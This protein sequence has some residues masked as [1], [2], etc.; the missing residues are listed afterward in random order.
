MTENTL[1]FPTAKDDHKFVEGE[2]DSFA[3]EEPKLP[4]AWAEEYFILMPGAG[5]ASTGKLVLYPWQIEPLNAIAKYNSVIYC[6]PVQ[7]G[8]SLIAEVAV[9]YCV[10]TYGFHGMFCYA[11]RDTVDKEP[12]CFPTSCVSLNQS[13]K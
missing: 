1:I 4:S 6:G 12:C 9:W 5:Y 13:K 3:M 2:R 10:D 7:T 8:K 11:K